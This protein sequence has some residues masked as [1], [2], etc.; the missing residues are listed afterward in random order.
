MIQGRGR[1][2]D[3]EVD[4]LP[5]YQLRLEHLSKLIELRLIRLAV[6]IFSWSTGV[7]P[8]G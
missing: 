8:K 6:F 2:L 7:G 1:P 5:V 4:A 3:Q